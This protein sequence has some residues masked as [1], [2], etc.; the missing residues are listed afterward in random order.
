LAP[1]QKK[2]YYD[3]HFNPLY[4]AHGEQ[5]GAAHILR[6]ITEQVLN[7]RALKESQEKFS[8][9]LEKPLSLFHSAR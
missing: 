8:F 6:N 7:Q 3:L 2:Q 4:D 5:I 9:F 1:L